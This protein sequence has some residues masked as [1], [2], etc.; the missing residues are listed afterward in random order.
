MACMGERRAVRAC[1]RMPRS[2]NR[3]MGHPFCGCVYGL[4]T[5]CVRA[6]MGRVYLWFAA[7]RFGQMAWLRTRLAARES[8]RREKPLKIMLMPTRV[9]MTQMELASQ[10]RPIMVA[11]M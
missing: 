6:E 11:G 2:Q 10:A 3:D 8:M 4:P 1:A 7:R 9:P 5:L